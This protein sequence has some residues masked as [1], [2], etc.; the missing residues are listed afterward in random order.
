MASI[1]HQRA[2]LQ[3]LYVAVIAADGMPAVHRLLSAALIARR[4]KDK[5][6]K[7]PLR[8]PV[9]RERRPP[10]PRG[11]TTIVWKGRQLVLGEGMRRL[12]SRQQLFVLAHV[13]DQLSTS[14]AARLAGYKSGCEIGATIKAAI[15]EERARR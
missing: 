14:A 4:S 12:N 2:E 5:G 8:E 11:P 13:H 15:A 10:K 6:K 7:A 3:R 9:I 1:E